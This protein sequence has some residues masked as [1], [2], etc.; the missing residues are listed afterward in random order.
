MLILDSNKC[1]FAFL[2]ILLTTTGCQSVTKEEVS[3]LGLKISEIDSNKKHQIFAKEFEHT[4]P[5]LGLSLSGGGMR[6]ASFSMGI[7]AGLNQQDLLKNIDYLSTVSGGGYAAYWYMSALYYSQKAYLE[8]NNVGDLV[9]PRIFFNDCYPANDPKFNRYKGTTNNVYPSICEDTYDRWSQRYRF[10][11][12]I[13]EQTDLLNYHMDGGNSILGVSKGTVAQGFEYLGIITSQIFSLP[14]HHLGNTLF[15]WNIQFSPVKSAYN[16]GLERAFGLYPIDVS[17]PH[18]DDRI[19]RNADSFLWMNNYSAKDLTFEQI[20]DAYQQNSRLC[21]DADSNGACNKMPFWILNTAA[22]YNRNICK[23]D[24]PTTNTDRIFEFTPL[25]YGSEQNGFVDKPYGELTLSDVVQLSG[26]AMDSQ[27]S[28]FAHPLGTGLL[29]LF[30]FNLGQKVDNYHP[31]SPSSSWRAILPIPF[32]CFPIVDS[33]T[34]ASSIYLSDGA[35][36]EHSGAYSLIRRGVKNIIMADASEDGNG[37]WLEL[38]NLARMIKKEH[39]LELSLFSEDGN[40]IALLDQNDEPINA[41]VVDPLDAAQNIYTGT[42]TGFAPGFITEDESKN[43]IKLWFIKTGL[44]KHR[45]AENCG[46]D[47][48]YPCS[49]SKYFQKRHDMQNGK[50]VVSDSSIFPNNSTISTSYEMSVDVYFAY[51]DLGKFIAQRFEL[52]EDGEIRVNHLT[53]TVDNLLPFNECGLHNQ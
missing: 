48:A 30:N 16:H 53:L 31:N 24:S 8:P 44:I 33:P 49:V 22:N 7:L 21:N 32:Y 43:F 47:E 50:C 28:M 34:E 41:K 23:V 1:L 2:F 18:V 26:A 9:K 38:K 4:N 42:V 45:L 52:S 20:Q 46:E 14:V 27:Y 25:S 19:Y 10:Q 40:Q 17:Q 37:E 36:V 11:N 15:D 6:S 5:E 13:A 51:R 29:H 39:N 35:H 3:H 12:Q